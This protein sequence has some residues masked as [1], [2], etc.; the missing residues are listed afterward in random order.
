MAGGRS[1]SPLTGPP[2]S[3][4]RAIAAGQ[5]NAQSLKETQASGMRE[6]VPIRGTASA[7]GTKRFAGDAIASVFERADLAESAGPSIGAFMD[8]YMGGMFSPL[9]GAEPEPRRA[10]S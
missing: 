5:V 9:A 4:S 2:G 7:A 8:S 10:Q 6:G 3:V 1:L